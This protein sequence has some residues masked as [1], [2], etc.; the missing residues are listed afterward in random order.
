MELE[1]IIHHYR[2]PFEAKYSHCLLPSQR[3]A[4]DAIS[5]CRTPASGSVQVHCDACGNTEWHPCSCGHR[6][7]PRCQNHETSQWL[8]RQREKLLP[9]DYFL[10]TFTIPSELRELTWYHQRPMYQA[11]FKAAIQ[12][13]RN[14]GMN[15]KH[16][17]AD[18]GMTAVLHTHSRRLAYH[19][20]IHVVVPGGGVDH[21][22]RVWKQTRRNHYL[23]NAF[24]LAKVFRGKLLHE[25]ADASL[26]V[27]PDTPKKWVVDCRFSGRGESAL[28]YLSRYLYRGVISESN[29]ISDSDGQVSFRYTDGETGEVRTKTLPG[30]EFLWRIIQHVL[31]RG[32]HRVRDYGF[33]HHKARK[34]LQLIQLIL[35]VATQPAPKTRK[36]RPPFHCSACGEPMVIV[37]VRR[38]NFS[39]LLEKNIFQG[40]APPPIPVL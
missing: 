8:D 21:K 6:S 9:V 2:E 38:R 31:P 28:K 35:Q 30:V 14:F 11:L 32:F 12:T 34:T 17:G 40:L 13:L 4:L 24:A 15:P 27:P 29:I 26:Q 23:F 19:P 7:C 10:V 36:E 37:G 22:K 16:L 1:N 25:I 3:R 5:R 20:H 33:L 18:M 39:W